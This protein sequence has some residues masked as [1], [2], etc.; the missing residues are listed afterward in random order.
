[1]ANL[2]DNLT[3]ML[4]SYFIYILFFVIKNGFSKEIGTHTP[5]AKASTPP[6]REYPSLTFNLHTIAIYSCIYCQ[7]QALEYRGGDLATIKQLFSKNIAQGPQ[8]TNQTKVDLG[9]TLTNNHDYLLDPK[10]SFRPT[11][12]FCT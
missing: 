12:H 11:V 5:F 4:L 1:M 9:T 8:T 7:Y 3:T 10:F 6:S 2:L